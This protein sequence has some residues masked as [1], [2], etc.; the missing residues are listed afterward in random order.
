MDRIE[1][2]LAIHFLAVVVPHGF[3]LIQVRGTRGN[4]D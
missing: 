3:D 4:P 1:D 2:D